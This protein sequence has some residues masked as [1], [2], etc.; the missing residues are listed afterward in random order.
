M[1]S[2]TTSDVAPASENISGDALGLNSSAV[3]PTDKRVLRRTFPRGRLQ[4]LAPMTV[5]T[6][7]STAGIREGWYDQ[8][9][10]PNGISR[11]ETSPSH[12]VTKSPALTLDSQVDEDQPET[13][14]KPVSSKFYHK[15][16]TLGRC[17]NNG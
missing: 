10:T 4:L 16:P 6:I 7:H 9:R 17:V 1:P 15:K 12:Q 3:L 8:Q 13:K 5:Q 14:V 11:S 2:A